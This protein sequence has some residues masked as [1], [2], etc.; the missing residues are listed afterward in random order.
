M[1]SRVFNPNLILERCSILLFPCCIKNLLRL[2]IFLFGFDL[3]SFKGKATFSLQ[4]I[5]SAAMNNALISYSF[6]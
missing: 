1:F 3:H 6:L 5:S 4:S 2:N